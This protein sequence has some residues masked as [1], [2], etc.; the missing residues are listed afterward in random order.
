M[1]L[2]FVIDDLTRAERDALDLG[3][4]KPDSQPGGDRFRVLLDPA[5]HPFCIAIPAAAVIE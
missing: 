5:G 3:A 2:D 1:H 4:I